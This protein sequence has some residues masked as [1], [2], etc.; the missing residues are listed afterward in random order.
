MYKILRN[1][2][3]RSS[4]IGNS[5]ELE[6][7]EKYVLKMEND[8][9]SGQPILVIEDSVNRGNLI[10]ENPRLEKIKRINMRCMLL[11]RERC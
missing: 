11:V 1:T 4:P 3:N 10:F 9:K 8:N 7:L 2:G 5:I 6:G